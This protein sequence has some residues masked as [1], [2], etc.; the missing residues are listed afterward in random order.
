MWKLNRIVKI[1]VS[2]CIVVT[3]GCSLNPPEKP[4]HPGGPEFASVIE[5]AKTHGESEKL[6]ALDMVGALIQIRE[7]S[8]AQVSLK[9]DNPSNPFALHIQNALNSA[10]YSQQSEEP[11]LP[12]LS[13]ITTVNPVREATP[14]TS[15]VI[16]G[17]AKTYQLKIR[18]II[19]R[20]EYLLDKGRIEPRSPMHIK[21]ASAIRVQLDNSIFDSPV[22]HYAMAEKPST[23]RPLPLAVVTVPNTSMSQD[24]PPANANDQ[25]PD[26]WSDL[27]SLL[28]LVVR[29]EPETGSNLSVG[30]PVR[31]TVETGQDSRIHCYYEDSDGT[32]A[33]LFP[34]RYQKDSTVHA[35]ETLILPES[36]QWQ[37][38]APLA[39]ETEQVMCIAI[40]S[41]DDKA[42]ALKP[43]LPDLL[44]IVATDLT[45][46]QNWYETTAGTELA[47]RKVSI[48]VN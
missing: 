24:L 43:L 46:I 29:A 18:N 7:M 41:E 27:G 40:A 45:E 48:A 17:T 21:G 35:G 31:I 42:I 20:R 4:V 9:V 6:V 1:V 5:M 2:L 30:D 8:P 3:S 13:V 25:L 34:N 32:V 28:P 39:G 22:I 38:S 44:P 11:S 14:A 36:N 37:L 26:A 47:N 16:E 23:V 12:S 10:G 19:L 15:Q 33:R